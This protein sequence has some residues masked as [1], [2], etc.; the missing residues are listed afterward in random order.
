MPVSSFSSLTAAVMGFS[1][2]PPSMPPCAIALALS[3]HVNG[4]HPETS[5]S[6][7]LEACVRGCKHAPHVGQLQAFR[8][9][10]NIPAASA[11]YHV[12]HPLSCVNQHQEAHSSYLKA[13]LIGK[14]T[15]Q[16]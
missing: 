15:E 2:P 13:A 14:S 12:C 5:S 11:M 10:R 9:F 3:R 6:A 7:G 8:W 4:K 16:A 1:W